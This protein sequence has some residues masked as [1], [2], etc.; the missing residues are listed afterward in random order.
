MPPFFSFTKD[1]SALLAEQVAA[2]IKKVMIY[3]N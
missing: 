2:S 1:G 3:E